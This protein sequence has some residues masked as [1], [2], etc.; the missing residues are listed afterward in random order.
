MN[1]VW[2]QKEMLDQI[3]HP[4][5]KAMI[6]TVQ[7]AQ[8]DS[9]VAENMGI[10]GTENVRHVHLGNTIV[11]DKTWNESQLR[12]DNCLGKSV[13]GHIGFRE[14]NLPLEKNIQELIKSDYQDYFTIEI[15]Q[16]AYFFDAHRYTEEAYARTCQALE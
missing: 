2:D 16:R 8:F 10:L 1:T 14:G 6:D 12:K 5:F 4:L 11:R 15:C 9:S 7:L 3:A 13:V